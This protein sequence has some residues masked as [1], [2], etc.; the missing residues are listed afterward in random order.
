[1]WFLSGGLY[2]LET[3]PTW[4]RFIATIN[5]LTYATDAV[6]SVMIRGIIW[7]TLVMDFVILIGF[8]VLMFILGSLSFKRTID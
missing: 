2:P 8:S 6:R 7:D 5:P 3:M 1:M 4:M